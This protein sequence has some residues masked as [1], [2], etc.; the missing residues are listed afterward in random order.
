[1]R[2]RFM[3]RKMLSV[4]SIV[5]V[6]SATLSI[7]M[8]DFASAA[9]FVQP[10]R[11]TNTGPTLRSGYPAVVVDD[12]KMIHF[13]HTWMPYDSDN[14]LAFS[15][16]YYGNNL[17]TGG[18][19]LPVYEGE[20]LYLDNKS[21]IGYD[22]EYTRRL[23]IDVDNNGSAAVTYQARRE[24]QYNDAIWTAF[25]NVS[26]NNFTHHE[27][28][29]IASNRFADSKGS[30]VDAYGNFAF[31]GDDQGKIWIY[32]IT[33][34]NELFPSQ[35][36]TINLS[37]THLYDGD[38]YAATNK[39][40]YAAG[41]AGILITGWDAPDAFNK[42][43]IYTVNQSA[44]LS[45]GRVGDYLYAGLANGNY[46]VITLD[47]SGLPTG[48]PEY[49]SVHG[50]V[51]PI[52]KVYYDTHNG[53]SR[54]WFLKVNDF[55]IW[56]TTV[57]LPNSDVFYLNKSAA[58]D[59][60]LSNIT[61]F[62]YAG[63]DG[64]ENG[65]AIGDGDR[66][67]RINI[68][69]SDNL[70]YSRG[71]YVFG[72]SGAV[73]SL[74]YKGTDDVTYAVYRDYINPTNN[75]VYVF[76]TTSN[77]IQIRN[78]SVTNP[79]AIVYSNGVAS[80]VADNNI[81]ASSDDF[82]GIN[83]TA[84]SLGVAYGGFYAGADHR[85]IALY[86]GIYAVY[87]AADGAPSVSQ[88]EHTAFSITS[89]DRPETGNYLYFSTTRGVGTI[90]ITNT[91][92][93]MMAYFKRVNDAHTDTYEQRTI[94]RRPSSNYGY[95][96]DS[97]Y[98]IRAID[99][100]SPNNPTWTVYTASPTYPIDGYDIALIQTNYAIVT[101]TTHYVIFSVSVATPSQSY[102]YTLADVNG[103]FV[104]GNYA[105]FGTNTGLSIIDLSSITSPVPLGSKS[106]L[107]TQRKLRV[108]ENY[109]YVTSTNYGLAILDVS[110][111]GLIG[112]P[113]YKKSSSAYA[114]AINSSHAYV[115]DTTD[116][117]II[118]DVSDPT[119]LV[120][121]INYDPDLKFY[122]NST[123]M[124][125]WCSDNAI[126]GRYHYPNG[127]SSD[128]FVIV[129]QMATKEVALGIG[130]D[131]GDIYTHVVYVLNSGGRDRIY[132][133]RKINNGTWSSPITIDGTDSGNCNEVKMDVKG[134][135][136][137]V[138]F[139]HSDDIQS[140][141]STNNGNSFI[142]RTVTSDGIKDMMPDVYVSASGYT[143]IIYSK[144]ISSNQYILVSK[145]DYYTSDFL[146]A[147]E[148]HFL[149][150]RNPNWNYNY[151]NAAIAENNGTVSVM[152]EE[153]E[154][155]SSNPNDTFW[156]KS[157]V[158]IFSWQNFFYENN[159]E[160]RWVTQYDDPGGKFL[161]E[162]IQVSANCSGVDWPLTFEFVDHKTNN[163]WSAS[164][165]IPSNGTF[166]QDIKWQ[167]PNYMI[168]DGNYTMSVY[169]GSITGKR[170]LQ[171]GLNNYIYYQT[172][173]NITV[174]GTEGNGSSLM[175]Y[176]IDFQIVFEYSNFLIMDPNKQ[177]NEKNPF[178]GT[179]SN[180]STSPNF[181]DVKFFKLDA[182]IIYN[183]SIEE[184]N[185]GAAE[186]LLFNDDVQ[187]T[188]D[189]FSLLRV[190]TTTSNNLT[191]GLYK[192]NRTGWYYVLLRHY[193]GSEAFTINYK[194][195][196]AACPAKID[197]IAPSNGQFINLNNET[198]SYEP[199]LLRWARSNRD[200]D[201][202]YYEYQVSTNITMAPANI[203]EYGI[204]IGMLNVNKTIN[205]THENIYY[206][207]VRAVDLTGNVGEWSNIQQFNFD[208]TNP[209]APT[210]YPL[211]DSYTNDSF[212]MTWTPSY[213][214]IYQVSHYNIY[215]SRDPNFIPG[216]ENIYRSNV[217]QT[218][219]DVRNLKNYR[220]FF[221][222]QAVDNVGRLSAFSNMVDTTIVKG[223]FIDPFG[224]YFGVEVGDV[225]EYDVTF[226]ESS[227]KN[228]FNEPMM[229]F[230]Y[231]YYS[232]GTRFHFWVKTVN[233]EEPQSIRADFYANGFNRSAS[234][235]VFIDYDISLSNFILST[236]ETYQQLV[237][238][239]YSKNLV[240]ESL[241]NKFLIT[242]YY[243]NW[244]DG[245]N[246]R[247]V[248][249]YIYYT[250]PGK[251]QSSINYIIDR[252]SGILLEMVYLNAETNYGYNLKIVS[253]SIQMEQS[254]WVYIPSLW[255]I[256]IFATVGLIQFIIKKR[257]FL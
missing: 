242:K 150:N 213:D 33:P 75:R 162:G 182:G 246:A 164:I 177:E 67:L 63:M 237:L 143:E 9:P 136:V 101:N 57:N 89:V 80:I 79:R 225:L 192:A 147:T 87:N 141:L 152:Y 160:F 249:C 248:V 66:L 211:L 111:P 165:T 131:A 35:V 129:Q 10:E 133:T 201:I 45:V 51:Q 216:S 144:A 149:E 146:N 64:P 52:R 59:Y 142:N 235:W 215:Y 25:I 209:S 27:T 99:F 85:L 81:Y 119:S 161:I 117:M 139:T 60:S 151:T 37:A 187:I 14:E 38:Y 49:K 34:P 155:E 78:Q 36:I 194:F 254:D 50:L 180:S 205:L 70:S 62:C 153:M 19:G 252:S 61:S 104:S 173:L 218:Y 172:P 43:W 118:I 130:Y 126:L 94:I 243:T 24:G 109:A 228:S 56:N 4:L 73:R 69:E 190:N 140:A 55:E 168:S 240:G 203:T 2:E 127:S 30:A 233:V 184:E 90:D 245:T 204:V 229:E 256:V 114:V 224:Q 68:R 169:N 13:A 183:F 116:G 247:D 181:A 20:K 171:I 156:K 230:Y 176:L 106:I 128:I 167:S 48:Y 12:N 221:K 17:M 222:I 11:L 23:A 44:V 170:L 41:T 46:C 21:Y 74:A 193:T 200:V 135:Y 29:A 174:N 97:N 72:G 100:S 159:S 191:S 166:K 175:P 71:S 255:P 207:R 125:A 22:L 1:M 238:D 103:V 123:A 5:L 134:K 163:T 223:G 95:V 32:N 198:L 84:N 220:Y 92:N 212:I 234:G 158:Y 86:E 105:Y 47:G 253:S 65:Y 6:I 227:I 18:W 16:V 96:T 102:V 28:S 120:G 244:R 239:L 208:R 7:L 154:I 26:A 39:T 76:N 58:V 113:I 199:L 185:D 115:A 54:I 98:G 231:R 179:L 257:E 91:M 251:T 122:R 77:I 189:S 82:V 197:L 3:K 53:K 148:N 31:S 42:R 15:D 107:G 188:N 121:L 110:N 157:E 210:I 217:A 93:P 108:V 219:V 138:A 88:Y 178:Y 236:N 112:D 124:A 214:G 202:S 232:Q 241:F 83:N 206:W 8:S 186:L 250:T 196:F 145:H 40:Y 195:W 226:V 137:S 132:Y